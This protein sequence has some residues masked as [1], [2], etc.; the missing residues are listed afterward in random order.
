M[1]QAF[2]IFLA[3]V[4]KHGNNNNMQT[5]WHAMAYNYVHAYIR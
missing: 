5:V 2:P 3:Y 4:E 1:D